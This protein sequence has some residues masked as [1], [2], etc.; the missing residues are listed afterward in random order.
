MNIYDRLV[1]PTDPR[2]IFVRV[3]TLTRRTNARELVSSLFARRRL[4]RQGCVSE[5]RHLI[6]N[7]S[8]IVG[9][10]VVC[11]GIYRCIERTPTSRYIPLCVSMCVYV[12]VCGEQTACII[13]CYHSLSHSLSFSSHRRAVRSVT[14]AEANEC[15]QES[16]Q[17]RT[18]RERDA[19][20][21]RSVDT[22]DSESQENAR[23]T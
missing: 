15:F 9:K 12:C 13:C 21:T 8:S 22:I 10:W 4:A 18:S 3:D 5:S 14:R 17:F 7:G 20:S 11:D 6:I 19:A 2:A 23:C 1:L 16:A